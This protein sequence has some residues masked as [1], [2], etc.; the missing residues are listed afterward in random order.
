MKYS[1]LQN[2][3]NRELEVMLKEAKVKLGKFRFEM[4]NKALKDF[5]QIG[6]TRKEI[7]Q[8]MTAMKKNHESRIMN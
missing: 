7:A 2:K 4:A 8:I 5:S 1:D 3:D 6:K